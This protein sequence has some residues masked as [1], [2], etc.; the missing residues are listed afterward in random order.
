MI[1][2]SWRT[3]KPIPRDPRPYRRIAPHIRGRVFFMHHGRH[4]RIWGMEV[5]NTHTGKV[6]ASDNCSDYRSIVDLCN[7]VTAVAR[8][9]WFW[10][11]RRREVQ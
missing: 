10:E 11:F 8:A 2:Y 1:P 4:R 5:V 9:A 3:P 7:E 6:L